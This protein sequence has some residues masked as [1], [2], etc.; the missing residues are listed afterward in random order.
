MRQPQLFY[1]I[2]FLLELTIIPISLI[3]AYALI[4]GI[5]FGFNLWRIEAPLVTV[6]WLIIVASPAWFYFLLKWSQAS[7]TRTA[8]VTVGVALPAAYLAFQ[9]FVA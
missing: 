4:V 9:V 2:R 6:A 5:T 8:M 3:A 7:F 1:A